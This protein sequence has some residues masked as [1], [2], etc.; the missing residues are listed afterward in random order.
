MLILKILNIFINKNILQIFLD[1]IIH[2]FSLKLF[3]LS[4]INN[5]KFK[6]NSIR[7]LRKKLKFYIIILLL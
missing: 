7:L 4:F 5:L 6:T 3:K 1:K 2:N